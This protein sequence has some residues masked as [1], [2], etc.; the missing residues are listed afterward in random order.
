MVQVDGGADR[1]TTP[2][3]ELVHDFRPPDESIGEKTTINDAGVHS[4]KIIGY[5]H[6]KVRCFDQSSN[7]VIIEVPCA[8]IPSIPSTLLNFRS[9]PNLLHMEETSSVLLNTA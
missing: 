1:S 8:C 4:H 9:M 3:R 2:H 5:G 6:F 7:P